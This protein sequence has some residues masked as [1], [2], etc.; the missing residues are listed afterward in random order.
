MQVTIHGKQ[1]E[2]GEALQTHIRTRLGAIS[3]KYL[4][5]PGTATVTLS[6]NGTAYHMQCTVHLSSGLTTQ[7]H[8]EA[9]EIY[10]CVDSAVKNVEKQLRRYKEQLKGHHKR[11]AKPLLADDV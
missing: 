6:R 5:I 1:I 2:T 10:A 8:A 11:P 3:D 4:D 7:A 9:H